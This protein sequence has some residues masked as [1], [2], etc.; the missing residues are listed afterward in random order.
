MLGWG[1][2]WAG[3]GSGLLG[4]WCEERWSGDPPAGGGEW[5]CRGARCRRWGV[6][7]RGGEVQERS[8]RGREGLEEVG[9][10]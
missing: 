6:E 1:W 7:V 4:G 9:E 2:G 8:R 10:V 5:R 3:L